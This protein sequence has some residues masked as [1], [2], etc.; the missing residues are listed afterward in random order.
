MHSGD[1]LIL[2]TEPAAQGAAGSNLHD[3]AAEAGEGVE[4][5]QVPGLP[6]APPAGRCRSTV[7][8]RCTPPWGRQRHGQRSLNGSAEPNATSTITADV[9]PKTHFRK[10]GLQCELVCSPS[11]VSTTR[12]AVP[13][14]LNSA[15]R[16]GSCSTPCGL[17]PRP[18]PRPIRSSITYQIV[19]TLKEP[20][21]PPDSRSM[22]SGD[23]VCVTWAED[24]GP[25]YAQEL[26]L[27]SRP[28][29]LRTRLPAS[30]GSD[31]SS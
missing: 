16:Q 5:R 27:R 22:L 9:Q 28:K 13:D 7:H 17:S 18:K 12:R 14:E 1:I 3:T 20:P 11:C 23:E 30:S 24:Q 4:D 10:A 25:S 31:S 19:A 2:N 8:Y 15:R 21:K 26:Y 29:A 6:V